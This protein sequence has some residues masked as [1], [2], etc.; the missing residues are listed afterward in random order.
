MLWRFFFVQLLHGMTHLTLCDFLYFFSFFKYS[1]NPVYGPKTDSTFILHCYKSELKHG[2]ICKIKDWDRIGKNDEMGH[3][4]ISATDLLTGEGDVIEYPI[5]PPQGYAKNEKAGSLAIRCRPALTKD[6]TS[7]EKKERKNLFDKPAEEV[8][9]SIS[10][11]SS[12]PAPASVPPPS[13]D[14][15]EDN[16]PPIT[17]SVPKVTPKPGEMLDLT[18]EIVKCR[19]LLVGDVLSSDPYVTVKLADKEIHQTK[20]CLKT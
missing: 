16:K 7:I 2:L 13:K 19:D 15:I 12:A 4:V 14:S 10:K 1:L 5:I 11:I 18:I 8:A 6:I 17:A 3:I 20:P 9:A